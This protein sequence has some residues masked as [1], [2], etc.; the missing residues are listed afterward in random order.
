M[1][2]HR[3]T[4]PQISQSVTVRYD[5]VEDRVVVIVQ[6][7]ETAF[8]MHLT[9][10]LTTRLVPA[11]SRQLATRQGDARLKKAGWQD[12]LLS[13]KHGRAVLQVREV[14][15]EALLGRRPIELPVHR[16]TRVNSSVDPQGM[17]SLTFF[18]DECQVGQLFLGL[19][20]L[21]WFLDRLVSIDREAGWSELMPTPAWL[22]PSDLAE[23]SFLLS[24]SPAPTMH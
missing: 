19:R 20:E 11:L 24:A 18:T 16:P 15:M 7:S 5:P 1:T 2:D 10:R 9:R 6:S 22:A 3:G 12:E 14:Q 21:H 13:I 23:D 17:T 4:L 8:I